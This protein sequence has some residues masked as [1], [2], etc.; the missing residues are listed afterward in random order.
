MFFAN[1]ILLPGEGGD[2]VFQYGGRLFQTNNNFVFCFGPIKN[3]LKIMRWS[4]TVG[5]D[6]SYHY[7][8]GFIGLYHTGLIWSPHNTQ[9]LWRNDSFTKDYVNGI[10]HWNRI[11]RQLPQCKKFFKCSVQGTCAVCVLLYNVPLY[12]HIFAVG[13]STFDFLEDNSFIIDQ[14]S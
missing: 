5:R 12:M 7:H 8:S 11:F 1:N 3:F 4:N 13:L 9:S 14:Y 10:L 6:Q 2:H